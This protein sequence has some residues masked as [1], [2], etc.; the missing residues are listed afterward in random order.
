MNLP[1]LREELDLLPGPVL[2]D[3]QP[4]WTLHDPARN[5]F[6][7][8]DWLTFE[9]L[10][11]WSVDD[12]EAIAEHI[13]HTTTLNPG[14][15]DVAHVAQFLIDNQ[16]VQQLNRES[17]S[18]MAR[19][20][21]LLEGTPLKWLLHHY[22]FFR[23]PLW[24]PDKWL[25]RWRPVA[26]LFYTRT[27][28]LLT[29]LALV[30]GVSMVVRNSDAFFATLVDTFN[31]SGLL[32]Y[33][34]A[35]FFVKWLHEL[36]HAFTAKRFGCRV[37]T[38]GIA[39][40]VMWPMAYT[41]TNETWRLNNNIQRLKV[42]CA[43]IA[44]ELIIAVWATLA[45]TLLP[46][47]ELRGAVFFLATTSWVATLAVNASPFL[48]F[49]GY[50]ILSDLLDIPNLHARCFALAR[51][52]LREWLFALGAV[53]PEHFS[54]RKERW[55]IV[56]AWV[57]WA[58]RLV[59][60]IG[61]A[62]LVYHFSFK[63]LGIFLF[64]VEI[65]WFIAMPVYQEL[66]VWREFWPLLR[67]QPASWRRTK[68]SMTAAACVILV[69]FVPFPGR[70]AS[71]GL[72]HPEQI[73]PVFSPG[74]AQLQKI[75]QDG[76]Q[77]ATESQLAALQS[78]ELDAHTEVLLAKVGNLRRQAAFAGLSPDS[79][80]RLLVTQKEWNTAE[81]EFS[82]A[83][84]ESTRYQP[85]APF[86]GQ[87][88]VLDPDLKP[89]QWLSAKEQLAVLVQSGSRL[90]IETY[91]NESAVQRVK[92]GDGGIFITDGLEGPALHFTVVRVDTDATRVLSNG[93]L[94]AEH[95]GHIL[96][97]HSAGRYIPDQAIYRVVLAVETPAPELSGHTWRGKVV[98]RARA[99]TLAGRYLKQVAAVL[100]RELGL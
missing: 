66:K 83:Q 18:R 13:R 57:T 63:I 65:T 42:A 4:T 16:L 11:R 93:L 82:S 50:F 8:I 17:A 15:E 35:L 98:I 20:L 99:Q 70:V 91:L 47:G 9:I 44:T 100:V 6:F 29:A 46:N 87:F 32:A 7:R 45:W 33:G 26:D 55:L 72:L 38:M 77:I 28:F 31:F 48:R 79:R 53:K 86:T 59:V 89:G 74:G 34:T 1:P 62:L 58:Y 37:P 43:G 25:N 39:F 71:S 52:K 88:H 36:G 97:R 24:N 56:F 22:L 64:I 41:D 85:Q 75:A 78:P 95:G 90:I 67:Q 96:T 73:W 10:N 23:I 69:A 81:A 60:F 49:D 54:A 84:E 21:E 27:F 2:P 94:S 68:R 92:V 12:E 5:L 19:H 14:P 76:A 3:G 40:L 30:F 61:I 51:W 80:A